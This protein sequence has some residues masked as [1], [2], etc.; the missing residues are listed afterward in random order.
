[1]TDFA[2]RVD[3]VRLQNAISETITAVP[4]FGTFG[5]THT[6]D[7]TAM[8]ILCRAL[9]AHRALSAL[10][11]TDGLGLSVQL[12]PG[13]CAVD[14][15]YAFDQFEVTL[16]RSGVTQVL[17]MVDAGATTLLDLTDPRRQAGPE[18]A[19]RL[20]VAHLAVVLREVMNSSAPTFT[21]AISV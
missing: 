2:I 3:P 11:P 19:A 13:D 18:A 17:Q 9:S 16:E 5:V 12:A 10:R 1:M 20:I 7:V 4:R 15:G 6:E 8:Q 21:R 14:A